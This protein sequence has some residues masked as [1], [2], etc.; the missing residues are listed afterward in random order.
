MAIEFTNAHGEAAASSTAVYTAPAATEAVIFNLDL[1]N[2]DG[3][4]SV[5]AT[6]EVTDTS[7]GTTKKIL[8]AL[9][10]PINDTF[11]LNGKIVLEATDVLKI[12]AGATGDVDYTVAVMEKS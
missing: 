10:I 11:S 4:N 3:T 7:A 6:V 1:A 12:Y 5:T 8:D 2:I 9:S